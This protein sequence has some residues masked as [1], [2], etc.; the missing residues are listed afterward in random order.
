MHK[1]SDLKLKETQ[2]KTMSALT[3]RL[4]LTPNIRGNRST[5]SRVSCR[6]K[7]T[8]DVLNT[9]TTLQRAEH[10]IRRELCHDEVWE[11]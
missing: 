11:F 9:D 3:F 5:R 2:A 1:F 6:L 10:G 4:Q 7:I 8:Q